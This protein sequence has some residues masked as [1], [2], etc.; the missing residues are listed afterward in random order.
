MLGA[1]VN[2]EVVETFDPDGAPLT[3]LGINQGYGMEY[4]GRN[5]QEIWYACI[6][7]PE[8]AAYLRVTAQLEMG[9]A[10]IA[11]PDHFK[12][13]VSSEN[14][15]I[16]LTP[17]SAESKGMA[18]T[19]KRPDGFT[20][21]ELLEGNGSYAFDW[22]VKA[23]RKGYENYRIVRDKTEAMPGEGAPAMRISA[24]R[25]MPDLHQVPPVNAR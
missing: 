14:M 8:A 24:T 7:G 21:V 19:E 20:V 2:G 18:V 16:M 1:T 15:T 4:P 22:E 25:A 3:I 13:V 11:F 12:H 6:K 5:D 9:K 23:V 10:T 17:L